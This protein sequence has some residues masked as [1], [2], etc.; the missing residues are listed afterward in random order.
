MAPSAGGE[1]L[2]A[3]PEPE[4]KEAEKNNRYHR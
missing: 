3:M 2:E 4:K 1:G